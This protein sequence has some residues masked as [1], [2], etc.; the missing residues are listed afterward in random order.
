MSKQL[1]GI[2]IRPQS[3]LAF[4]HTREHTPRPPKGIKGRWMVNSLS[5]VVAIL[6]VVVIIV[7]IGVTGY[8]YA[9]LNQNLTG[10]AETSAT[11]FNNYLAK[12]TEQFFSNA[13]TY[14]SEF[15]MQDKIELQ[16]LD[17]DGRVIYSSSGF[18]AGTKPLTGDVQ[19]A[20]TEEKTASWSGENPLSGERV[21]SSTS[22]IYSEGKLVGGIRYVSSLAIVEKQ[23]A[24]V[25]LLTLLCCLV[26]LLLVLI[27]G[28]YFLK[29]I[30]EPVKKINVIAREIAAGRYGMR[31]NKIYDDEIGELCDT[32]NYMS[33][34][35][36]KA[37]KIKNDFISSVSHELRTPLTAIGGWSETLIAC[38]LEDKE[39]ALQGL[40]IIQ[41]E[42]RRLSQMVE[43]LLDFTR[44]ESGNLKLNV[45]VF[46]LANELYEAVYMYTNLLEREGIALEFMPAGEN[47]FVNGDRHRLKQV[48]LNII[49]NA[50][51]YGKSGG[52]IQVRSWREE[53]MIR[54]TVRD[55]GAGIP[56]K[57]LPYVKQKFF[58]GSSKERG[59]GIGLAVTDEI[60]NMHNGSLD[61]Q[62]VEGAGTLVTVSLP[63]LEK[64]ETPAEP[65][66]EE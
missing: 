4:K 28:Q 65:L 48:F 33:D 2:P 7:A 53:D 58:K 25:L 60:V 39:Q 3:Q 63:S 32:I 11:F 24:V 42:S 38:G 43:E 62:S 9:N 13:E 52:R 54:I 19:S 37:E 56:E 10:R 30:V 51:K 46:D 23:I 55:F 12:D 49:D 27:F 66:E 29:S 26:F 50:A 57:E 17:T 15:S 47:L 31:L 21:M 16:I 41:K 45:E 22:P 34:E 14:V 18:A 36:S 5:I 6:C 8:Y 40:N 61:I 64:K 1:R 20:L 35:I 59:N 44:I